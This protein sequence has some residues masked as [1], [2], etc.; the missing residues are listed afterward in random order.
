[1]KRVLWVIIFGAICLGL[2]CATISRHSNVH[3]GLPVRIDP[4]A[5]YLIYL[6]GRIVELQG[7]Q[8]YHPHHGSYDFNGIVE[9]FAR[10]GLTVIA[11]VRSSLTRIGRY[12]DKVVSQVK[13]LL[14]AGVPG[15]NIT[16]LG[17]SRGGVMA[18]LAATRLGRPDVNFVICA[19][20]GIGPFRRV[21]LRFL[22][23]SAVRL[24]GRILSLYDTSDRVARSCRAAFTKAGRGLTYR[25][26]AFNTGRGHG[27]FY[28]ADPVWIDKVMSWIN[29]P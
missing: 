11:E 28:R 26:I 1:M 17:F 21:F 5:K 13:R 4:G 20:C 12:A 10:R 24:R 16:V 2:G 27:L 22:D 3:G 14:A 25:E 23:R 19:G 18:L 29:R 7:P 9:K 6:H 8:A 15:R